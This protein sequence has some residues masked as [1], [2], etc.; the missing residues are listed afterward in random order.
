MNTPVLPTIHSNG[1]D[2]ETLGDQYG[3]ARHEVLRAV[4]ALERA[5]PHGRDF[6]PQGPDAYTQAHAEHLARLV[7]LE[8]VAREL[9]IL[10]DH[11]YSHA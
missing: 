5:A 9:S 11:C 7:K 6:Y 10:Q 4:K 1:T 3:E 8:S 2:Y